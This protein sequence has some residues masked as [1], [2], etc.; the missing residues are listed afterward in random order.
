MQATQSTPK[1]FFIFPHILLAVVLIGFA[2]TL[3]LRSIGDPP[4]IPFYLHLHGMILTLW[5]GL[6]VVQAWLMR[7]GNAALHRTLGYYL[8]GYGVVVVCGG[9]LAT[10]N[11]VGRDLGLGIT[12][13]SDMAAVAPELGMSPGVPY[14][15][16][17][18]GVVWANIGSVSAFALLLGSAVL[19]RQRGDW[20][21]RFVV[22][23][24]M[25]ILPPALARI[26]R[27]DLF[28]GENPTTITAMLIVLMTAV[29]AYDLVSMRKVHK[30]TI[31][32]FLTILLISVL[33][34]NV[35]AS[36]FGMGFV[37]SLGN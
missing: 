24:S 18:S 35:G 16:F 36:E 7:N 15:A 21:K 19:Q 2:P 25:A 29:L 10:F 28:G 9:L 1:F 27:W 33:M 4:P 6:L 20:H 12:F 22:F 14:L 8:A 5:Y 3:Y 26:S 17:I 13:E 34:G 32:G 11:V 23:A 30:A 37:R 31:T